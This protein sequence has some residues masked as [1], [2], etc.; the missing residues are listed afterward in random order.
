M[1][2]EKLFECQEERKT[3]QNPEINRQLVA[4]L[5]E[6]GGYHVEDRAAEQSARCQRDQRQQKFFQRCFAE[7][8]E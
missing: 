5:F 3:E 4:A 7:K 2:V 1:P 8:T 6:G